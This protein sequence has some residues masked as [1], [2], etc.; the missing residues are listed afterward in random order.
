VKNGLKFKE[1][2]S[3]ITRIAKI[4]DPNVCQ[5]EVRNLDKIL[6]APKVRKIKRST[7]YDLYTVIVYYDKVKA[8]GSETPDKKLGKISFE[9]YEKKKTIIDDLI[10]KGN[11]E[12]LKKYLI[13]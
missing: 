13:I 2:K 1:V 10:K 11:I 8:R 4:E 12:E 6:N 7:Y 3:E 9:E 5:K